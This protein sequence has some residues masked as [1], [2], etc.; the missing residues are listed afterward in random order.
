[1]KLVFTIKY[2]VPISSPD[3]RTGSLALNTNSLF[4]GIHLLD[5]FVNKAQEEK[6]LNSNSTW[7]PI[8]I[9]KL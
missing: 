9:K 7:K 4:G 1:M 5:R 3:H 8:T 2:I 6:F